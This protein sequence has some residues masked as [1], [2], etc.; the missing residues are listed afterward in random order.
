MAETK[1]KSTV[2]TLPRAFHTLCAAMRRE[3]GDDLPEQSR[4]DACQEEFQ[5]GREALAWSHA[6]GIL[7]GVLGEPVRRT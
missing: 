6:I 7:E 3:L 4:I 1:T 5:E 2:P